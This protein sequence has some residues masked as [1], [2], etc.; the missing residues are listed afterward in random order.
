MDEVRS[1]KKVLYLSYDGMSDP[2]G[3]SQVLPFLKGLSQKGHQIY[4]VS[5]EKKDRLNTQQTLIETLCL[6]YNIKWYP[7]I[8]TK[9]PPILSTLKDIR[10]MQKV[11]EKII[12]ENRIDFIHCRSYIATLVGVR[13][14]EKFK[15]PYLF[16]M[17][18]FWADERADV[19]I[20]KLSNPIYK[21]AYHYFKEKEKVFLKEAQHIISLTENAKKIVETWQTDQVPFAPISVIPCCVDLEHFDP[22]KINFIEKE[23]LKNKLNIK[24][25]EFVL[26]YLGSTGSWYNMPAM[27]DFFKLLLKQKPNAKFLIITPDSSKNIYDLAFERK[28][29]KDNLIILSA[30]RKEV[31]S[32][33]SLFDASVFFVQQTFSKIAAS[34]TK[35]G[36]LMAMG[37]PIICNA[38]IG[39]LDTIIDKYEA[40]IVI[41]NFDTEV[42]QKA[43]D[44]L[45]NDEFFP[46]IIQNGAHSYYNLNDGI[47]K[48]HQ[49]Y[50]QIQ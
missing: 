13:L 26:G 29:S 18:G 33:I 12:L 20:W 21:K 38:K 48:Y 45:V 15:T 11:A 44:R 5:F 50:I 27:M 34:P 3:Q 39:D 47:E 31:P 28:I 30:N 2:L 43:V 7:Q 23:N 36:E 35:L 25:K 24:H 19:G 22:E 42:L 1:L 17:C 41:E 4:L 46:A 16:D 8:Y 9:K 40:G 32:Y 10:T 37:I 49:I 14:K 6:E